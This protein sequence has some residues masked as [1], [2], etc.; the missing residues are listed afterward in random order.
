MHMPYYLN[1]LL[2]IMNTKE[3]HYQLRIQV[4]LNNCATREI[5]AKQ[6]L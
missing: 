4:I 5:F 3:F 1:C 6:T 2:K